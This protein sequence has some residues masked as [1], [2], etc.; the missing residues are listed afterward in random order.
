MFAFFY[1]VKYLLPADLAN[2]H[3]HWN[4]VRA[5]TEQGPEA[6]LKRPA[7]ADVSP[8]AKKFKS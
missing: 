8:S 3:R 2:E 6:L 4:V 7:P 1:I 5:L